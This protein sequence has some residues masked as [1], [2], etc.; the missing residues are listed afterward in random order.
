LIWHRLL[1]PYGENIEDCNRALSFTTLYNFD[2]CQLHLQITDIELDYSLEMALSPHAQGTPSV[3]P[4]STSKSIAFQHAPLDHRADSIRLIRILSGMSLDGLIRCTMQHT[5]ITDTICTCLSYEW[6]SEHEGSPISID[7]RTHHVVRN[8]WDFLAMARH[9]T[10]RPVMW[11]DALC[12][13]GQ[14]FRNEDLTKVRLVP[15]VHE[16]SD[17]RT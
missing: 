6:G 7:G 13:Y 8:L 17:S 5:V 14:Q 15:H 2:N 11:I 3:A 16:G 10:G 1:R 4:E 12:I 9:K